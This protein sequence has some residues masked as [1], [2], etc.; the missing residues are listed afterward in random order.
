MVEIAR[1]NTI[2]TELMQK[3]QEAL[4]VKQIYDERTF[5]KILCRDY[6]K[7]LHALVELKS[8]QLEGLLCDDFFRT[9]P[10]LAVDILAMTKNGRL[11]HI[12][13]E[14][15]EPIDLIL[16]GIE[17]WVEHLNRN[18]GFRIE[19]IKHLRFPASKNF[20]QRVNAATEIMCIW[21]KV[22]DQILML[23][24][25]DISHSHE[26][27]PPDKNGVIYH[28]TPEMLLADNRQAGNHREAMQALFGNDAIWHYSIG[29][30]ARDD[31]NQL[32]EQL[33]EL[34]NRQPHYKMAYAVPV[35]NK[36][37]GTYHTKLINLD[38]HLELELCH[39]SPL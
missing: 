15:I 33:G 21:L 22:E 24:L 16:H 4:A 2:I 6:E 11:N 7:I 18:L 3:Y 20:Q 19:V 13:F 36:Y 29:L 30:S 38:Q 39:I 12:G 10:E 37:D 9:E 34:A 32:H 27:L 31:V 23:E 35:E 14:I 25:F 1:V 17:Y 26:N 5:R 8:V 28:I